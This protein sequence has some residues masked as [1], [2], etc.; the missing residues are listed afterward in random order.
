MLHYFFGTVQAHGQKTYLMNNLF[1]IEAHYKGIQKQSHFFLFPY[2]D[3]NNSTT[4][5]FAFDSATQKDIFTD[6]LKISGI[7]P[8]TAYHIAWSDQ[9]ELSRA[10]D[11]FDVKYLQSIPGIGP[12]TAKRMLVELKNSFSGKDLEKLD[13]DAKLLKDIT[14]SMKQLGYEANAVKDGLKK[15]PFKLSRDNL[16]EILKWLMKNI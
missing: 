7:G 14:K 15:I 16:A 6:L 1:G 9:K 8:K 13:I 5:Y 10:I 3:E 4:I 12:K 11:E 2:F